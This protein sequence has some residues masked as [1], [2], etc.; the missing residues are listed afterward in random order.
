M[1]SAFYEQIGEDS[2]VATQATIGP[3][4]AD[5]Q[6][7][8]P[9]S[10]LAARALELHEPDPRQRLARVCV[11]ILHPVPIA[12]LDV[13]T[14]MAR[15]GRRVALL[16]AVME[17]DGR[18]V[19]H[20]RGWRFERPDGVLPEITDGV[21]AESVIEFGG[22]PP[23]IF[24]R[25]RV[26]YLTM[27][28]WRFKEPGAAGHQAP[29]RGAW[30]RP[31]IP[32]LEGEEMSSMSRALLIADSGSGVGAVLPATSFTF[33]NTDLTVALQRDPVGDW[34]LLEASTV[35]GANGT[36]LATTRLADTRGSFGRGMQT[37]L[38]APLRQP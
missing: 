8:G 34:L 7:G 3:W 38:V 9:P 29:V 17:A 21:P 30:A 25:Q 32:L 22:L 14:R 28:E 13:R 11:D 36:G 24:N 26:G 35:I 15:P 6:H 37:L 18:E 19:L 1:E 20:A 16:E 12:K 27:I 33:I 31:R 4:S 10:A 23:E 5:A 2:F